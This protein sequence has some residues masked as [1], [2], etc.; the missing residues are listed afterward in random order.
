MGFL[1]KILDGNNKEMKQLGNL[2]DKVIALEDKT[3][4]LTYEEI[5]NKTKQ[6]PTELSDIDNLKKQNGYL[7]K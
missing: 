6:F 2:A 3:T 5:G 1:S 4:T 7:D